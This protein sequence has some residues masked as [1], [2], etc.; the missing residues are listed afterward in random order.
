MLQTHPCVTAR[1]DQ[2]GQDCFD[3]WDYQ[4]H[5]PTETAALTD[6]AT[7]GWRVS[8][9]R[10][11]CWRCA[12]VLACQAHGHQFSPWRACLGGHSIPAHSTHFAHHDEV[13]AVQ[14][15][16]CERCGHTEEQPVPGDGLGVA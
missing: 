14:Y 6:L 12:A 8:G 5:W 4:P 7:Q 9:R 3:D 11:V 2:C 13:C 10:L 15:R 16:S 1:C